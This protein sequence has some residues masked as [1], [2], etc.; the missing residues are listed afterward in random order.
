[1]DGEELFLIVGPQLRAARAILRLTQAQLARQAGVPASFV[2][3]IEQSP[4]PILADVRRLHSLV[5]A[6]NEAGVE[7]IG[8]GTASS[9]GGPGVR[10][11]QETAP[12]IEAP[13]PKLNPPRRHKRRII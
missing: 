3:R 4:E 9:A 10:L 7:L 2:K 12:A 5:T 6:L 11:R 8:A 1:M 13:E